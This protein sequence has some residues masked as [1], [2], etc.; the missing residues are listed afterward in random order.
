MQF[1]N[2]GCS[3]NQKEGELF[4]S[5][6]E[7][8]IKELEEE[9][10]EEIKVLKDKLV[11][12][13]SCTVK[14]PTESKILDLIKKEKEKDKI[15]LVFGCLALAYPEKIRNL[16]VLAIGEN[17]LDK[18]RLR[19]ILLNKSIDILTNKNFKDLQGNRLRL[20]GNKREIIEINRGCLGNCSFCAT[21][22]AIPG[23]Y[24]YKS[25]EIVNL[26]KK[27]YEKGSKE[28][29]LT[30][31][32]TGAYGLDNKENLLILIERINKWWDSLEVK[33]EDFF[34]RIG[35]MNPNFLKKIINDLLSE[36]EKGPFYRFIHLPVQSGSN[37]IL[38]KMNRGYT[39][40]DWLYL[41]KKI[42]KKKFT[43]A[44][45][46]IVA[47]PG[48]KE[49]DFKET[50]DL[51]DKIDIDIINISRFWPRPKTKAY[52]EWKKDKISDLESKNR[53]KILKSKFEEK[54]LEIN[55]K[56]LEENKKDKVLIN[57]YDENYKSLKGKDLYYKQIVI[58]NTEKSLIWKL[59]DVELINFEHNT[60]FATINTS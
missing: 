21:K 13:N 56:Y 41:A 18:E 22:L 53:A 47:Y 25:E 12:I 8:L 48:E 26:I 3:A 57:E 44:T 16:N 17:F 10:F 23:F 9:N 50:L 27:A 6:L 54:L 58:K 39:V 14:G 33:R 42:K 1:F 5:I 51:L 32:D 36:M 30:S 11:V 38:E 19:Q 15:V 7:D 52:E 35:M 28:I 59:L 37:Y 29:Y 46:I 55:K 60:F 40:E 43:L 24:S 34:I 31:Q 45:D 49:E 2:F 4:K 20:T